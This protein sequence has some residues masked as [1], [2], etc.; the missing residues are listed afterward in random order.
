MTPTDGG[1]RLDGPGTGA[2]G[3]YAGLGENWLNLQLPLGEPPAADARECA[4]LYAKLLA[5]NERKV[6]VA[7]FALDW[8]GQLLLCAEVPLKRL[9]RQLLSRSLESLVVYGGLY[10][11]S[12]PRLAAPDPAPA[13][14]E[15][16]AAGA[17]PAA[18]AQTLT[19]FVGRLALEN[20]GSLEQPAGDTWKLG[21]KGRL[22]LYEVYLSV[23]KS[24]V[25]FQVPVLLQAKPEALSLNPGARSLF[26][27]YLLRLNDAFYMVKFGLD[28]GGRML[29]M[30]EL[31]LQG[32]T[33]DLFL[34]AVRTISRY[35]ESYTQELEI[36]ASPERDKK[37]FELLTGAY[38]PAPISPRSN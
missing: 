9:H 15:G 10:G 14:R 12:L 28:E 32:L 2:R 21:Y 3:I 29:L 27:R 24:W 16:V 26:L 7:K 1:W 35:L 37:I 30:L 8:E 22:R 34:T 23:T 13:K 19:G 36:M 4:A 31:P 18:F 11:E 33:Y 17:T 38:T 6:L 20:W 5:L 25:S